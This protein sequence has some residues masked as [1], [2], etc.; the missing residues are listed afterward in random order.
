MLISSPEKISEFIFKIPMGSYFS[1]KALRR[2]LALKAGADN[3]CPVT[4]GI[5]LRMAIEQNKDYVN[6][7]Y[8]IVDDEKHPVVKKLNLY[9]NLIEKK[10]VDESILPLE[11]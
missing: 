10:N 5:F 3:T 2:V 6:F 1:I 8:W 11:T 4:T 7:P 9:R